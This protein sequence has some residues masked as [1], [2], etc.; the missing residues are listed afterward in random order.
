MRVVQVWFQNRRAKD[1]RTKKDDDGG[2]QDGYGGEYSG[3]EGFGGQGY[4]GLDQDS[5]SSVLVDEAADENQL[6][7]V[8]RVEQYTMAAQGARMHCYQEIV[9]YS[10]FVCRCSNWLI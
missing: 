9:I 3:Q 8:S 6:G 5:Y 10:C 4:E 1:K 7:N 2:G